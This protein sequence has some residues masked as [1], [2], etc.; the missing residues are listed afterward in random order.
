MRPLPMCSLTCCKTRINTSDDFYGAFPKQR[1][2]YDPNEAR[3]LIAI[4]IIMLSSETQP[5][6]KCS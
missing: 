1:G 3:G 2:F 4:V 6:P 5:L